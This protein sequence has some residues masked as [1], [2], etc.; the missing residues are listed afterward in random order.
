MS[1]FVPPATGFHLTGLSPLILSALQK[2]GFRIPT[3]I[4]EK[5][6]PAALRG[7]DFIGIAQTGTGKTLAFGLPILDS[8]LKRPGKALVIVPTR[9]LALQVEE[10][11]QKI[12]RLANLPLRTISLVGGQPMYRQVKDLKMQPR[13]LIATPG[14]LQ[15]HLD[16]KTVNLG[17]VRIL[18]LDEADRL[19]DMGFMP[20]VK[21]ILSVLT[22]ERHTM[23]FSATMASEV[24]ALAEQYMRQPISIRVEPSLTNGK[25]TQELCY[26]SQEG[27]VNILQSFLGKHGG[28]ILVFS[29]T[30]HGARKLTRK[31]QEMGHSAAEIH[32]DR[33]LGQRR[34]ALDGFKSGKYRVLV[35]TDVASRGIDVQD[36]SVVINYDLPDAA[37]DYIHRIG[38]TGRAGKD[39]HAITL[40]T[41]GQYREVKAIERQVRSALPL[42]AH[43]EAHQNSPVSLSQAGRSQG[44]YRSFRSKTPQRGNQF[45]SRRNRY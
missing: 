20:Q 28:P 31:V 16:Q 11:I 18:V 32:S 40:A 3:P 26:V 14:R 6:I 19:L 1:S 37:E 22:K 10:H 8:L 35:A 17:D 5:A 9:E 38:R 44:P 15:D 27:K 21:K 29:R 41:H 43:S 36:I 45:F 39:G 4:Q 23:L 2:G 30:K 13:L 33:S 25:I 12:S 24:S 7:V 42:S 34:Q